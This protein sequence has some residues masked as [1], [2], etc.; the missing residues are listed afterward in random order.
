MH[1][2]SPSQKQGPKSIT[3]KKLD[4][5]CRVFTTENYVSMV[6]IEIE[7]LPVKTIVSAFTEHVIYINLYL[8]VIY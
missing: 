6:M 5:K 3:K 2:F 4:F 7:T 8:P 1:P